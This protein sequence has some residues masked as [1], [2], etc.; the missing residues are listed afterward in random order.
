MT[1][2]Y[3]D[4]LSDSLVDVFSDDGQTVVF[5]PQGGGFQHR[6]PHAE[7][8]ARFEPA[9]APAFRRGLVD[10]DFVDAPY[11]CWSDGMHWNGWGMPYFER[12]TVEQLIADG[13]LG[14]MRWDGDT[15]VVPMDDE[16]DRFNPEVINGVTVWGIGAGC[17]CWDSVEFVEVP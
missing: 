8:H 1:T 16:E 5:Y 7:F 17:Y 6:A 15:V 4:T 12:E 2:L 3:K 14:G 10:A 13:V 9:E 11:P